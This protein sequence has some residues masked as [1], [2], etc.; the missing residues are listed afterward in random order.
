MNLFDPKNKLELRDYI[1]ILK[2]RKWYFIIPFVVVL[3]L[4]A[5]KVI[6]TEPVYQ[7]SSI[8]QIDSSRLLGSGFKGVVPG[9]TETERGV[10]LKK[11]ILS[12]E[13]LTQLI[14]RL[15]LDQ[16]DRIR[17]KAI[18][19]HDAYPEKSVDEIVY[20]LLLTNLRKNID[21]RDYGSG[22]IEIKTTAGSADQAYE[23]VKNLT[24]IF[25]EESLQGEL[26]NVQS[27]L[28]FNTQQIAIYKEKLEEAERKLEEYQRGR[29]A[30][31][32]ANESLSPQQLAHVREAVLA[33]EISTEE[34][35]A[36]L[37]NIDS[38]LSRFGIESKAIPRTQA[39]IA[40]QRDID[41]KVTQM[42][43]LMK[44]FSSNNAEVI[45]INREINGIRDKVREEIDALY[46]RAYPETAEN[47]RDLMVEKAILL[48]DIEILDKKRTRLSRIIESFQ[49]S[50]AQSPADQLTL[51]KLQQ[52]VEL[53]RNIYNMFLQQSQGT[54]IEE[55]MQRAGASSRFQIIEPPFRPLDPIN[56]GY[57]LILLVTVMLGTGLG[58]GAVYLSEM[59]DNSVRSVHEAETL[60]R[61]PVLGVLPYLAE[62]DSPV[63]DKRKIVI[64]V[65]VFLAVS[66]AAL[67]V[68][69]LLQNGEIGFFTEQ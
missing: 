18:E 46:R 38:Q 63:H 68:Y 5:L 16:G 48:V 26:S 47:R 57:K 19:K 39:I 30:Q 69:F 15:R 17:K 52:E 43:S 42:A 22:V 54:Q 55:S 14:R 66:I 25:I 40:H 61:I 49:D 29:I 7:S 1:R 23:I 13:Y 35:R 59:M 2:R 6:T 3:P 10:R 34:K 8:L 50:E 62:E 12:S 51:Q 24:D 36:R 33:A 21:I 20:F 53:T 32:A 64:S 45:N 56:A 60:L 41:N 44:R 27:A 4:G 65:S 28:D 31:K 37:S 11:K 67:V 9:V 58:G